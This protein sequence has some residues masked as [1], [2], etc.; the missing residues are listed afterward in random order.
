MDAT[1]RAQQKETMTIL[2]CHMSIAG[3]YHKA[4][5][6]SWL[7]VAPLWSCLGLGC[8]EKQ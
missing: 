4:A 2:G 6:G 8:V 3:G 5:Q 1:K 7:N